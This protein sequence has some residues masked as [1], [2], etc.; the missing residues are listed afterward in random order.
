MDRSK[1]IGGSDAAGVLNLSRWKTPLQVWAEK[2]G[3]IVPKEMETEAKELGRELENYV[4]RRF[5]RK[6]GKKLRRVN[7]TLFHP[8]YP[9]LGANVDR[10]LIGEDAGLECK[11]AS[12]WKKREWG[13]EEIPQE[14]LIQCLHYMAVTGKPKWY[15]AVLVGNEEFKWK[16]IV[17]DERLIRD[18]VNKEVA[19]WND[20]VLPCIMPTTITKRDADTLYELFP[21]AEEGSVIDLPDEANIRI[22]TLNAN[23]EDLKM[24]EGIIEQ[25]EN[26][27]KAMLKDKERGRTSLYEIAWLPRKMTRMD[28]Q[29]FKRDQ[30]DVYAKYCKTTAS[31]KFDYREIKEKVHAE[32][33]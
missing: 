11:T 18:V 20:Y 8:K 22:E 26:E 3:Q 5:M 7:E 27:L 6:T 31:R 33:N 2:T 14:Y 15:I 25:G 4:A 10:L 12:A 17:R 9:F 32:S 24:I 19:F 30:P 1:F 13:G 29:T 28:L 23:K 16:E 21:V